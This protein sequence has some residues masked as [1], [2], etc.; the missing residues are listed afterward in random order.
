MSMLA[1]S[2]PIAMPINSCVVN[3]SDNLEVGS[4]LEVEERR[5]RGYCGT[6]ILDTSSRV[7]T[8]KFLVHGPVISVT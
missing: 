7:A 2:R 4:I 1:F 3:I 5:G 6:Y 8:A